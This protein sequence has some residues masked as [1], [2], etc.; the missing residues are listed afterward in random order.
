M[1]GNPDAEEKARLKKAKKEEASRKAQEKAAA[2]AAKAAQLKA[3]QEAKAAKKAAAGKAK[4][5]EPVPKYVNTTPA[6]EKK[7][8][9]DEMP[10]GYQPDAVEAAWY[11]WWEK[12]GFFAPRPGKSGKKFVMMIPPP[13]VTGALHIGHALTNSIED[14]IT[15]WHRMRGDEALWLPGLDHAGIATQTVVEKKLMREENKTRH[16]IGRED[17]VKRVWEWKDVYGGKIMSQL[18]RLGSSLDWQREV[19]TLDDKL[20]VAVTEAFVKMHE[21]GVIFRDNRLINYCCKLQTAMSDIEVDYISLEKREKR[22]VPGHD[23]MY[24]FGYLLEFAYKVDGSD[25][26]IVVATTR[27]ETMLGDTAVAVHPEDERYK[28]LHGKFVRHP[29]VDR[30]IPII[31][32]DVLVDMSFGTGAVKVTPA[33]DPKDFLTG[34]R[35]KLEFINILTD[36]GLLNDQCGK[37]QGMKRFDARVAVTEALKEID[38]WR[39]EKDNAMQIPL[40]SRTGDIIEPMLKPQWWVD[41]KEMAAKAVSALREGDLEIIPE[42]HHVTWYNW[43]ENIRD[44]CISR[45]LWWGHRIPAYLVKMEGQPL[46]TGD[47]AEDWVVARTPEEAADKVMKERNLAPGTSFDLVQD[48]DVL[49][50]WF[51]SGLFPFSTLGWPN[52]D[53]ADLEKYF[54]NQLLETGHDILFFWVARMVMMSIHLTGKLPFSR[55][56][57][58]AMVRDAHGR[59]MSKTLGNVIDPV[60]V[61]EGISLADL[62]ATIAK[63]NLAEKEVARA[64]AG[65]AADYPDGIAPCGTD[66]LRFALCAYTAQGKSIN[67]DIKRVEGYRH[68]CNKLWN[69]CKFVM[70][71]LKGQQ[72][73]A[74]FEFSGHESNSDKW[75]LSRLNDT[76]RTVNTNFEQFH[77]GKVTDAI[78]GFWL[79]SACDRLIELSKPTMRLPEDDP[80]RKASVHVLYTVL[81]TGLRLLH[82]FM[83]FVTE[84]LWQHLGRRE[85]DTTASI[86]IADYPEEVEGTSLIDIVW[87]KGFRGPWISRCPPFPSLP[88]PLLYPHTH[89][90][91]HTHTHP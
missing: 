77:F 79:Y 40:C 24:D 8:L 23:G 35:H 39:G 76:I 84:E 1:S 71:Y 28:H 73:P 2:K 14:T 58:H 80:R 91:T 68:F 51:S 64:Q 17:F 70:G 82:P 3:N 15:R 49:D 21:D 59:K 12:Q 13:N 74:K 87:P 81:E 30:K 60:H 88:S 52:A 83:P 37:F 18:R 45:Q 62:Q 85:G 54:P 4:A 72:M 9:P 65:Q 38:Q 53:A 22:S 50:T 86:M 43:L 34:K 55:V 61:I 11:S 47:K 75:I 20:S 5:A 63:G 66:A 42:M 27:P 31:T 16:D 36:E 10:A 56:F 7:Q 41:C 78:Y 67:L 25:E 57:L 19:F 6:G 33:H 46:P 90:H 69:A 32:D 29:F 26:E 89:T 48:P 44:W